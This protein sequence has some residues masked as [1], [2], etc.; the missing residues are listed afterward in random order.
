MTENDASPAAIAF[1]EETADDDLDVVAGEDEDLDDESFD[2]DDGAVALDDHVVVQQLEP[3]PVAADEDDLD[4]DRDFDAPDADA[5]TVTADDGAQLLEELGAM[6]SAALAPVAGSEPDARLARVEAAAR[7][8]AQAERERDSKKVR[9]KVKASTTG[10]GAIGAIPI[11]LQLT[12][13]LHLRPELAAAVSTAAAILGSLA[14]GWATPER[15]P[16]AAVETAEALLD[17]GS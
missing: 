2:L 6:S 5:G 14:A 15:R 1:D 12:G 16:P 3:P 13:A 10:A 8:L 4:A 7:A 9:R 11:L 17:G